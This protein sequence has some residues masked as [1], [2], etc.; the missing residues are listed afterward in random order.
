MSVGDELV[1]PVQSIA[2]ARAPQRY[3]ARRG[4]TLVT[5]ADR[6][7]IS[8]E[9]LR[10]WNKLSAS[11]LKPGRVL[12]VAEPL[13]LASSSRTRGRRGSHG[14]SRR[15]SRRELSRS[16]KSSAHKSSSHASGRSSARASSSAAHAKSA[17][18]KHK[19][20]H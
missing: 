8:P 15:G 10:R 9:E 18:T 13:R 4:D 6:F 14:G 11:T 17:H 7:N 20:A 16:A 2:A 3:T 19:A 5:I 1:V 12:Y